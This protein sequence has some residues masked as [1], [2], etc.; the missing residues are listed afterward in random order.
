MYIWIGIGLLAFLAFLILRVWRNTHRLLV[1]SKP[2]QMR[3]QLEVLEWVCL[4]VVALCWFL[5]KKAGGQ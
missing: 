4:A 2:S 3:R 1:D 5:Y